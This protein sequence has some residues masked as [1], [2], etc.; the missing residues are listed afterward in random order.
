[1]PKSKN[2]KKSKKSK[3]TK[4]QK[5]IKKMHITLF[6]IDGFF[7][8]NHHKRLT[9]KQVC[10]LIFEEIHKAIKCACYRVCFLIIN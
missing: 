10:H 3:K 5:K 7:N 4:N 2:Q 9:R 8:Q 6:L 1:M